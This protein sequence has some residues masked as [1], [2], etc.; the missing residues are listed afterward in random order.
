MKI[1]R[2][3]LLAFVGCML[4]CILASDLFAESTNRM[5]K[6]QKKSFF[7][8]RSGFGHGALKSYAKMPNDESVLPVESYDQI[9]KQFNWWLKK[10]LK[11][12]Y[13]PGKAF[14]EKNIKLLPANGDTRKE[15]LAFLS[16]EIEGK[17]YMIVQT[18]GL[19]A[20][21]RV[22]VNDP[23]KEKLND[24][25]ELRVRA[26]AFLSEHISE[27]IRQC[28]PSFTVKK[29]REGYVA[30]IESN[31]EQKKVNHARCFMSESEICLSIQKISFED[32]VPA[33]EP[34]PN[35]WFSWWKKK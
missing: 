15:D 27:K 2:P 35:Q 13:I 23:K 31:G 9:T 3:Y 4:S 11:P 8:E 29:T 25:G 14:V 30:E 12:E 20:R 1:N 17:T 5:N 18:G 19:N 16:Y 24:T 32:T 21:M 28:I 10:V 26:Q 22:F 34:M 33:R 6:A 7:Q